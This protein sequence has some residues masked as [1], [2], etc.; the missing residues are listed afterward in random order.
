VTA[1][2]WRGAGL[3]ALAERRHRPIPR[4][5]G[6]PQRAQDPHAK[7][8]QGGGPQGARTPDLRRAS[9]ATYLLISAVEGQSVSPQA[10]VQGRQYHLASTTA[11]D[12][13]WVRLPGVCGQGWWGGPNRPTTPVYSQSRASMRALT[14]FITDVNETRQVEVSHL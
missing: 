12:S 8:R 7:C 9:A 13:R 14:S 4:T 2:P 10:R 5:L 1:D 6:V 11:G 3:C